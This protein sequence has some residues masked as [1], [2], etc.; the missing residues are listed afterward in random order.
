MVLIASSVAAVIVN[1]SD[2][3]IHLNIGSYHHQVFFVHT[4]PC[5]C[6]RGPGK[7]SLG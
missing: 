4:T 2:L 1:S 6:E 7:F 3:D 5:A